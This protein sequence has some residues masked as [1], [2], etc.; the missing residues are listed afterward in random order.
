MLQFLFQK[1]LQL[2]ATRNKPCKH[3]SP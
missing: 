2:K 1:S 3:F